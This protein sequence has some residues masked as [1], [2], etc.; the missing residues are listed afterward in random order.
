MITDIWTIIWKETKEIL[1]QRGNLRG[2]WLGLLVFIGVFGIFMPL[3]S[4]P[5]WVESPT[6]L[7][8]W[9]WVPFLLVSGVVADSFAGERERH[10][11]ETLLASRLS[12]R[13]ILFGKIAA[14]IAYGWGITMVSVFLGLITINVVHWQGKLS[15]YPATTG[16]GIVGL[17]FLVALLAAGLGVLVS[18]RAATVRQAQQTFS[19]AFFLLF[20]PLFILPMLPEEWRARL[21]DLAVNANL[22]AIVIVLA[23]ILFVIDVVLILAA[24]ARFKRNRL[25]LD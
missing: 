21:V 3:Q 20:I 7:F 23:I 10:T 19:I 6:G 12:D 22:S 15:L 9:G 4:G 24:M 18:L 25:I 1:F 8:I 5:E 11:L 13:A 2:G 16:L 17:S 14:A